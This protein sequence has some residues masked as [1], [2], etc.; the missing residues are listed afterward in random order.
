M[1]RFGEIIAANWLDLVFVG[2]AVALWLIVK[3]VKQLKKRRNGNDNGAS[4]ERHKD[5]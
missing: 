4:A 2:V 3:G 5:V 1:L